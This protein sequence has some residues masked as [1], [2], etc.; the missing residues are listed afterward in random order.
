[1]YQVI[2]HVMWSRGVSRDV[3]ECSIPQKEAFYNISG[4]IREKS[5]IGGPEPF[6][7]QKKENC[8][9]ILP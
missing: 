7:Q 2:H 6:P 8:W 1:M 9:E 5:Q 4:T 3:S